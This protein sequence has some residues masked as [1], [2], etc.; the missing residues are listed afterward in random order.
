MYIITNSSLL[1]SSFIFVYNIIIGLIHCLK[2][3]I[4]LIGLRIRIEKIY[5]KAIILK[6]NKAH[7]IKWKNYNLKFKKA[8]RIKNSFYFKSKNFFIHTTFLFIIRKFKLPDIYK[9]NGIRYFKEKLKF[10]KR[11]QFGVF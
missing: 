1:I 9:G 2:S 8:K 3:K 10:K 7:K 5:K 11:K 6:L 4:V